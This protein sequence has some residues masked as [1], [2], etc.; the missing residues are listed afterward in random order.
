MTQTRIDAEVAILGDGDLINNASIVV[1]GSKI[2]FAGEAEHAPSVD[3]SIQVPV[4]TPGFWDCHDHFF[5][6]KQASIETIPFTNPLDAVLRSVWDARETLLAGVTSVREVGGYGIHLNKAIAD[7]IF[8]GP[9]IYSS[10]AIISATAGHADIHSL[11]LDFVHAIN[12]GGSPLCALA[13][14]VSECLQQVRKQI[15]AG[16]E[17]IKFCASGGVMSEIDHPI[18]QQFSIEEQRAIV[19]EAGRAEMAVAA[20]CYGIPGIKS[21]LEAGVKTIE[22]GTFITEELCELMIEKDAIL[23]PT[24][25]T[26]KGLFGTPE[27]KENLPDYAYEKG[28]LILGTHMDMLRMAIKKGVTIAMG[29]DI[30]ISGAFHPLY[31]HGDNLRELQYLVEAGMSP[32]DAIVSGTQN[33]PPT[34]GKRAPKSGVLKEGYDADLVLMK[35][36]PLN[37]IAHLNDRDQ[38]LHIMKQGKFVN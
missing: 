23:V 10:N 37:N 4:I 2:T 8:I 3:N 11:P 35:A 32:M 6:L 19:E 28:Q 17:L 33:G 31:K 34:L 21:A 5:G 7:G 29:T 13:D 22:H 25:Y 26:Y 36:N 15:R 14:G 18:H 38:F 16:A 12:K 20:H 9:R 30:I 27:A 1:E 24:A